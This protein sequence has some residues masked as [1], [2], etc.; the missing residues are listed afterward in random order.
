MSTNQHNEP[1]YN[2][3]IGQTI[4]PINLKTTFLRLQLGLLTACQT[5]GY[6]H[7]S[8]L[9]VKGMGSE[10]RWFLVCGMLIWTQPLYMLQRADATTI[11]MLQLADVG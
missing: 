5:A 3:H 8:L 9:L 10:S 6:L 7:H 1:A 11:Y 2:L 4:E